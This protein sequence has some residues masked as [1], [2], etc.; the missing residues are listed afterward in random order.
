MKSHAQSVIIGGGVVGWVL[1]AV[2]YGT[3]GV[4]KYQAQR[5]VL[6][7]TFEAAIGECRNRL[8]YRS[9]RRNGAVSEGN[10]VVSCALRTVSNDDLIQTI[11]M[12]DPGVSTD[13]GVP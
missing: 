1:Q 10:S 3:E 13:D 8:Y 2:A 6:E 12:T 4:D 11:R 5:A 7:V 9:N